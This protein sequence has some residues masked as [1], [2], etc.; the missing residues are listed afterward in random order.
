MW[1][2]NET[3]QD[4]LGFKVHAD[5]LIDV[6]KDDSVLPITIGVF[7][8]W[9]S[10][11][12]SILKIIHEKFEE[13][14]EEDETLC[15]Y[16]NGWTFEG[17]DDAK[18]AL[19]N[20]ILSGIEDNKKLSAEIKESIKSKASELWKSIN[21][22]RGAGMVM[23]NVALPAVAAYFTGGLSLAPFAISKLKEWNVESP[24]KLI[25][26][27]GSEEGA[28]FF[29]SLQKD[30]LNEKRVKGN[31]VAEFRNG[32]EELL[33][34][35]KFKRLV[36]IIDDLDR[37]KPER[38]IDNLEAIKLFVNVPKT[39]FVIGADPRIVRHAIE[40]KY[41]T[42]H[43]VN[44]N[45]SRIIDDYL[46]KLLHLPYSLPKLSEPEVETYI[47]MLICKK[48]I[49]DEKFKKVHED[50]EKFRLT[51]KY[52]TY[53]LANIESVIGSEDF[54]S[55]KSNIISIP[56]LVPLITHSLYGNPR[57]I[58][59]FLNIYILR[60]RLSNV[61][62]LQDFSSAILAK[63]MILEYAEIHLFEQLFEWQLTQEGRPSQMSQ[64]EEMCNEK[65]ISECSEEIENANFGDWSK[66][67]I[68]KWIQIEP[69]LSNVD[70]R[71]Y[72]WI[73]RDKISTSI[74]ASSLLPPLVKA[75]YNELNK[76]MP[77]SST[78]RIITE[79]Y[80]DFNSF[81]KEQFLKY[82][83]S[84]LK[85]TPKEKR[86]FELFNYMLEM[87][88]PGVESVYV[89]SLKLVDKNEIEPSVGLSLSSFKSHKVMGTFLNEYFKTNTT[90]AGKAYNLKSK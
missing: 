84:K 66:D 78:K 73:S 31:P 43:S 70:L 82:L 29:K 68:I 35:T 74:S 89:G 86:N 87:E 22:M 56:A 63:L 5:L 85:Q 27:L 13:D 34:A 25:E 19:L 2:D 39:A 15:I 9:G 6:I 62:G 50:F 14:E 21:W 7:G 54:Q 12:S 33:E 40:F 65:S 53:G 11:K 20:S 30:D 3:S 17:Y 16:F 38:I 55:V 46:E 45:N 76:E 61:A 47:S 88:I 26:K 36:V 32:F 57:Q 52:S 69:K 28:E 10:G 24:E 8:D 1:S 51:D 83:S 72:F 41:T 37:C 58:K 80:A 18:A 59:R 42:S 71:D 79:K 81:E 23:K 60:K 44:D 75:L 48:E 64:L 90:K 49:G 77:T 4:L 67:K